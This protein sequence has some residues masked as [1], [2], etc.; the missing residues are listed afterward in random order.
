MSVIYKF[1]L[2]VANACN[3]GLTIYD[4]IDHSMCTNI[5]DAEKTY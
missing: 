1:V 2:K 3:L 4:Y 5:S